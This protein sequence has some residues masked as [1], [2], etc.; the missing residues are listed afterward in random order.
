MRRNMEN[1]KGEAKS[2]IATLEASIRQYKKNISD[3]LARFK[4]ASKSIETAIKE[5]KIADNAYS[6]HCSPQNEKRYDNANYTLK[7]CVVFYKK[8]AD[9][10]LELL[11]KIHVVNNEIAEYTP[12]P[13]YRS[14]FVKI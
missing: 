4:N 6:K 7:N 1:S 14:S 12:P 8:I 5:F 3:N 11:D 2:K 13:K 10:I 9:D